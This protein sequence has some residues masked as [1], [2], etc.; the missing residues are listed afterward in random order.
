MKSRSDFRTETRKYFKFLRL[1]HEDI[2]EELDL[3]RFTEQPARICDFGCGNGLTTYGLALELEASECIGV[4]RFDGID[5]PE[6]EPLLQFQE[7]LAQHCQGEFG[8]KRP[9]SRELC[10]LVHEQR[11]PHFQR[12][13]FLLGENL[14]AG[15]DLAYCKRVLVNVFGG[16]RAGDPSSEEG[17]RLAIDRIAASIRPQGHLIAVEFEAFDPVKAFA[18][19]GLRILKQA[20]LQRRD[21]RSRG[22][23]HVLSRYGL[24]LCQKS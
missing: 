3:L 8:P 16:K 21:V 1:I 7:T 23:T 2:R 24:F 5:A 11:L 20:R 12:G 14:P 22:R 4:D 13:D 10:S 6:L 15:A 17:L 18:G 19:S 9:F